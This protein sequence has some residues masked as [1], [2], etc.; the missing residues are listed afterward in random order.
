MSQPRTPRGKSTATQYLQNANLRHAKPI[1]ETPLLAAVR[2]ALRGSNVDDPNQIHSQ[3]L[4]DDE[5]PNGRELSWNAKEV[6]L[7]VGGV[8][9]K[10]WSFYEDKE[11]IQT[12]CLGLLEQNAVEWKKWFT[13]NANFSSVVDDEGPSTSSEPGERPIFGPFGAREQRP[14]K[15][16]DEHERIPAIFVFFRSVARIYLQ[17]GM[18]Y[19]ISL[20]FVVRKAWPIS[21]HG[22]MVQRVLEASEIAEASL[23]G[24]DVLP[25]IF[26]ITSPL[27]EAA[28]VGLAAG[29]SG[30]FDPKPVKLDHED[31]KKVL[32][33]VPPTEMIIWVSMGNSTARHHRKNVVVTV[34]CS[35]ATLTIWRYAHAKPNQEDQAPAASTCAS[36]ANLPANVAKKRQS[37]GNHNRRTS[38]AFE[39]DRLDSKHHAASKEPVDLASLGAAAS[40]N[41]APSLSSVMSSHSGKMVMDTGDPTP[42]ADERMQANYWM[43]AVH[44]E[45]ISLLAHQHWR[46]IQVAIWDERWDGTCYKSHLGVVFRDQ[47]KLKVYLLRYDEETQLHVSP[48]SEH[49]AMAAVAVLATRP[50]IYDVITLRPD[51]ALCIIGQGNSPFGFR[52]VDPKNPGCREYVAAG[53]PQ[54]H[55]GI[56]IGI[57]DGRG[58]S[59]RLTYQDGW[60]ERINLDFYPKDQL[61]TECMQ[62]LS[63]VLPPQ[64]CFHLHTALINEWSRNNRMLDSDVQFQCF[65]NAVYLIL[66]LE[67]EPP[68]QPASPWEKLGRTQ[69]AERYRED[70]ALRR[71]RLP[72]K[73]P[74]PTPKPLAK[75][76]HPMHSAIM[77]TLHILGEDLRILKDRQD[78]VIKLAPLIARLALPVRP[79]WTD[80]WKRLI[81]ECFTGWPHSG[82]YDLAH[83]DDRLPIWPQDIVAMIHG[84]LS[85]A[86]ESKTPWISP[87]QIARIYHTKPTYAHDTLDPLADLHELLTLYGFLSDMK[88]TGAQKRAEAAIH[89]LVTGIGVDKIDMLP[90]GI[91]APLREAL[92]TCQMAPP[93]H[94]P[95]PSYSQI[96]RNDLAASA[97]EDPEE[98]F[99]E[100]YKPAKEFMNPNKPRFTIDQIVKEVKTAANPE[101]ETVT[102]VELGQQDFTQIRFG[103]DRRLDEV[104]R[105]LNSATIPTIKVQDRPDLSEHDQTKEHQSHVLR[106]SERTLALPFGRAMFTFG[107]VPKVTREAHTIPKIEYSIK[108]LPLNI[109]VQPEVGR[110]APEAVQWGE[111][112]NGVAAGLRIGPV[113]KGVESSWITFNKPSELTP[114]HAGFLFALGLTGH[115]KELMTWHT[116]QYLTPKHDQTSIAVL[117]GLSASNIGKGTQK[118]VKLLAVHTPALLPTP[119]VDLNV[120]LLTQA[121]GL[122]GL[123]IL[124]LGT[125]NRR[126][127]EV[128]LSEISRKDLVQPDLS[129]EHREAYT[130]S[131]AI[132]FGMIMLGKGSSIPADL[133]LLQR[134]NTL[135][136]GEMSSRI[137]E[138]MPNPFD[139]NLTSPAASIAMGMFYLKTERQDVADMLVIPDTS[140]SLNRIQPSFLMIRTIARGL[141]M[142]EKVQ[143]TLEWMM[144]QIPDN[145]RNAVDPFK[146]KT[147]EDAFELAYYNILAGCC[148]VIGLKY[149]GTARQE[150]YAVI[151]KHY[152]LFSRAALMNSGP[153]YDQK[154]KRA[155]V[156]DGLNQISLALCMVM[157]GTGEISCLRRIRYAYGVFQV[158]MY[159]PSFR[160][161][162]HLAT[163]QSLGLLFLGAGRYTLGTSDAALACMIAAFFPRPH[164][165]SADNKCYLQAL[166]HL[167][168]LAVEP[169]CLIA[170]DVDTGEVVYLPVKITVKEGDETGT[171]QLISPTLIPDI[172]KLQSIRVDTPRYWPFYLDTAGLPRHRDAL[173]RNQTLYVK[174]RTAFLSY[175][176]DPRGSRSL[177]VRSGSSAG[178]AAILDFP[179]VTNASTHPASD[180]SEFITSFSNNVIFLAWADHMCRPS[181]SWP[182][183]EPLSIQ[184]RIFHSYTHAALLDC[185]MQDKPST[186]Q[187]HL[188]LL[189][190][191][192]TSPSSK[193]FHLVLQDL[194]FVSRFY[195]VIYERKFSG[196]LEQNVSRPGL[197]RDTAVMGAMHDLK[198][199]LESFRNKPEFKAVLARYARGEEVGSNVGSVEIKANGSFNNDGEQTTEQ[200]DLERALSWYL[201]V[202][203]VPASTVLEFLRELAT[204]VMERS[205]NGGYLVE[206]A[207]PPDPGE[208]ERHHR[209]LETG[210]KEVVHITGSKMTNSPAAGWALRSVDEV[211]EG[212]NLGAL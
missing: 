50:Y 65:K 2:G 130:F 203:G 33:S 146:G 111:F 59:V 45:P 177:F 108:L 124:Y 133:D 157:A 12:A 206:G 39:G 17:N 150:A 115:L 101:I 14:R 25:T 123:G 1:N 141:I 44:S 21:P 181:T 43:Q 18:S 112:H 92:R 194:N 85:G 63:F 23:T 127:A 161:G 53:V 88:T 211:I 61:V 26:T 55:H 75:P 147:G 49:P 90:L 201:V 126:M 16:P 145:I 202:N 66:G 148:F 180:L 119:E 76:P 35:T 86:T 173:L 15:F 176:E 9:V 80:Y 74:R 164:V 135:I 94:W 193:Y 22:V 120:H 170:R 184:E 153:A 7:S 10:K 199:I 160:F 189:K 188:S 131:A 79:E 158:N 132:A 125:R 110:I 197:V 83:I 159:H 192:S 51:G 104:A 103:Q 27:E 93:A 81:P 212:W 190:Y 121:A 154:I 91:A 116:F 162:V 31:D 19:V 60:R 178:D 167:W 67:D 171:S 95:L 183:D 139:I 186:L 96:G 99:N 168:V 134:L 6:L 174:R 155:A 34:N 100:G 208:R 73:P 117:L 84:M 152:D 71:L 70:P 4:A 11:D 118:V 47:A 62:L 144:A 207:T 40:M 142:W 52:L 106:V 205:R 136:H 163:M 78:S 42:M 69:E 129:N 166:R 77:F 156:R 122:S 37:M 97:S 102:G 38:A 140:I 169:R 56:I 113:A 185:I 5:N 179:Q 195:S 3:W 36:S 137:R 200:L 20:P 196:G 204:N 68:A 209:E 30:G 29:I 57:D 48:L 8:M 13:S 24:E 114:E 46:E 210:L 172:N 28:A 109:T 41:A 138:K 72:P 87:W 149:A 107:S 165:N 143:P 128:C 182:S 82:Q 187:T 191:R 58:S 105:L 64:D 54:T 89:R 98:T 151:V 175:T 198:G 32:K